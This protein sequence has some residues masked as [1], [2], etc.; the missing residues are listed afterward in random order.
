MST[1]AYGQPHEWLLLAGTSSP[2]VR[3]IAAAE[4]GRLDAT[5]GAAERPPLMTSNFR[6]LRDL[7]GVVDLDAEVP[8]C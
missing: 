6:L 3:H 4:G 2:P 1:P 8:H 5:D 7:E